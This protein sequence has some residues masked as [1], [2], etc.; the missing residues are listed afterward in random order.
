[1]KTWRK[2]RA[3]LRIEALPQL[4]WT[5]A[6]SL[7]G[8]ATGCALVGLPLYA[9]A[10][11]RLLRIQL[12]AGGASLGPRNGAA[13][14]LYGVALLVGVG[15]GVA[16]AG[17][18]ERLGVS[19]GAPSFGRVTGLAMGLGLYAA[20]LRPLSWLPL[21]LLDAGRELSPRQALA[22]SFGASSGSSL[23]GPS[24]VMALALL[25]LALMVGLPEGY[26]ALS[27][28]AVAL[29][30]PA[31]A[32]ASALRVT[33]YVEAAP[34]EGELSVAS[35]RALARGLGAIT[36]LA[37]LLAAALCFALLLPSPMRSE[38]RIPDGVQE[39]ELPFGLG[40]EGVELRGAED[41]LLVTRRDG[42]GAG[43]VRSQGAPR[44]G[45]VAIER[46]P[47]GRGHRVHLVTARGFEFFEVDP[48]GVRSDDGPVHRASTR[49]GDAGALLLFLSLLAATLLVRHPLRAATRDPAEQREWQLVGAALVTMALLL[50]S[51]LT[52]A[53]SLL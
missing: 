49:M 4:G 22:A 30:W 35:G 25:P 17:A 21:I 16:G 45:G 47:E 7:G 40:G 14:A 15:V 28:L 46:L 11:V 29:P 9:W 42:G 50:A 19:L 3:I 34:G 32:L 2:L 5:L 23:D 6:L 41:G 37:S 33:A 18:G 39:V 43:R 24:L 1:M 38:A 27:S 20:L 44:G 10:R 51:L 31:M 13:A 8:L 53:R 52:L 48:R 26:P 12:V 36:L